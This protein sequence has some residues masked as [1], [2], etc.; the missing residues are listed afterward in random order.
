MASCANET[1]SAFLF[2]GFEPLDLLLQQRRAAA[3]AGTPHGQL[4]GT[5]AIEVN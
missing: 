4:R 2:L 1:G 5:I 3:P